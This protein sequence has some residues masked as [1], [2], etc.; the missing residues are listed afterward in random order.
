M[1]DL[2]V[3]IGRLRIVS[4]D[5]VA[6]VMAGMSDAVDSVQRAVIGNYTGHEKASTYR[7]TIIQAIQ[8]NEIKPIQVY[9]IPDLEYGLPEAALLKVDVDSITLDTPIA[10]AKFLAKEIWP[11]AIN[12]LNSDAP[13]FFELTDS[14]FERQESINSEGFGQWGDF[15]GKDTALKLIAGMAIALE[16]TQ[17][18]YI[19][20]GKL[21][22][23]EV[24]RTAINLIGE[25]G[26]G[27]HVTNKALIM[28]LDEAL[29]LHASKLSA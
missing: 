17:G 25:Y 6:L 27:I 7:E 21:N 26:G 16:K 10:D 14:S 1:L 23:S 8:L 13:P 9:K 12:E 18:K 5:Q 4:L 20:G 11:W 24:A 22:K 28:L 19:R 15:A 2:P 3:H 29:S